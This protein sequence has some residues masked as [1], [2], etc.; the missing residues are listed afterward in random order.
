MD[1]PVIK[2]NQ[3]GRTLYLGSMTAQDMLMTCITTEWDPSLG[4]DLQAQGYQRQPHEKHFKG[5]ATYLSSTPSP[6][7]PNGALL[8]SRDTE[9]G[10]L[11]FKG[12][13]KAGAGEFGVLTIPKGRQLFVVD[14]QHRLHA[15]RILIG[16]GRADALRDYTVPVT[17]MPD[18]EKYEEIKQF[19]VIN[20]KQRRIDTDLALALLQTMAATASDEELRT[21]VGPGRGYRIRATRLTFLVAAR[22]KG[23]WSGRI[24]QPHDL[25]QPDAVLSLKSFADSLRPVISPRSPVS[26]L[27]DDRLIDLID[28]FWS[29]LADLMGAAFAQ[30]RQ[31]LIQRT[32]G[33]FAMHIVAAKTLFRL[34]G[35]DKDFTK[36]N[37]RKHLASCD[38]SV[39]RGQEKYMTSDFWAT[40]GLVRQYAS[41]AGQR[42]LASLISSRII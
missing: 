11:K 27:S 25:P 4:W 22:D 31:Y 8:S 18:V 3:S 23:P 26:Q 39:K 16:G 15:F 37:I 33:V 12:V 2:V 32:P 9:Y 41:S 34:C 42:F 14:Y 6:F 7:L 29:A 28:S 17:I 30:P 13:A 36:G 21:L 24:R 35:G 1:L 5:I 20:S 40:G 38:E 19:H 10:E